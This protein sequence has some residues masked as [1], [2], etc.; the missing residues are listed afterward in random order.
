MAAALHRVITDS[1]VRTEL[2]ALGHEQT[3]QFSL[4]RSA[5]GMDALYRALAIDGQSPGSSAR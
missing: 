1:T 2:V 3:E 5:E 4:A